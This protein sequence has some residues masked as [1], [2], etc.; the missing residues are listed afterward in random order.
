MHV[1]VV[2]VGCECFSKHCGDVSCELVNSPYDDV[3][4]A[5]VI[6]LL[7]SLSETGFFGEHRLALWGIRTFRA[8]SGGDG[9]R[10]RL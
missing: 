7:D 5:L 6:E 4:Q 1:V 2:R 8:F 9:V 10:G 3:G